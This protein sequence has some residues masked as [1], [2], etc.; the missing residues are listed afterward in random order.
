MWRCR[1]SFSSSGQFFVQQTCIDERPAGE[2]KRLPVGLEN[3]LSRTLTMPYAILTLI[4]DFLKRMGLLTHHYPCLIG[5]FLKG[6]GTWVEHWKE[7]DDDGL[8]AGLGDFAGA[9]GNQKQ[10]VSPSLVPCLTLPHRPTETR[11]RGGEG[12]GG[13]FSYIVCSVACIVIRVVDLAGLA[14][15]AA[16]SLRHPQAA[17]QCRTRTLTPGVLRAT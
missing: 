5:G 7:G 16:P 17:Q 9:P 10:V 8:P 3:L 12:R 6:V 2:F 13:Q 1:Y 11:D 14:V 15:L 4:G